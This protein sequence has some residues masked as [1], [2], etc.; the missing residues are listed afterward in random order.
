MNWSWK[1][2]RYALIDGAYLTIGWFFFSWL[3]GTHSHVEPMDVM[4]LT[5]MGSWV[6]QWWAA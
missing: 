5:S 3:F 4:M 1:R 2:L 6:G